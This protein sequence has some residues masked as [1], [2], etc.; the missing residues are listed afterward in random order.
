MTAKQPPMKTR[1]TEMLGIRY[2]IIQGGMQW[3]GRAELAS[4]VSN[5][6]ALGL[7]T[8][9]TQPSPEALGEEIKRTRDMTDQPFGINLTMLPTVNSP[10]YLRYLE[11]AIENGI[12]IMETAG[13]ITPE[14]IA[15]AKA[16]S[17][18]IVHKCVAVRH[19]LA[20]ERRG[21]DVVSIDSFEC[22][23]HPGDDDIGGIV[24]IPAAARQLKIPVV[25]SG[26][27]GTGAQM[28]AAL[29]LGAD[30]VNMG[31]RFCATVEAPIHPNIKQMMVEKSERDTNL[32]FRPFKNTGRVMKNSVSDE[33]VA[34]ERRPGAE[35]K[36]VH[37]LVAGARGRAAL[38]S[39]D[40]EGGLVWGGQVIGLI[41]DVP[42]CEVLVQRMVAECRAQLEAGLR[43][44][45]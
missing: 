1:V 41:D 14:V 38:D 42:T 7:L 4:A 23:G 3:V 22:A 21:V 18:K 9:L 30:G 45:G 27:I 15:T 37:G 5:A 24:L 25:A 39:G 29:T 20:A 12:R 33:V 2:P 34:I 36:D 6:G 16:A 13:N 19:A 11:V 44:F 17:V 31:T 10:N 26:G 28:A 32:I 43:S 40:P 8:A 35:F